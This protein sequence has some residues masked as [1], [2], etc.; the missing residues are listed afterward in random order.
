MTK[1]NDNI[2]EPKTRCYYM[3]SHVAAKFFKRC[4]DLKIS[5]DNVEKREQILDELMKKHP[6]IMRADY[7][8]SIE[9]VI[10]NYSKNY[11]KILYIKNDKNRA[12]MSNKLE[13]NP[14]NCK[15]CNHPLTL[16]GYGWMCC[17]P[18]C[19]ACGNFVTDDVNDMEEE[20]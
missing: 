2:K 8:S 5:E 16:M 10:K 20:E 18:D 1:E 7:D 3:D 14:M 4:M 17:N 9:D 6:S 13:G 11:G 19:D 12:N 15:E